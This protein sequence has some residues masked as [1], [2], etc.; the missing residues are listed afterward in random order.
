VKI[1]RKRFS[2]GK[3][4]VIGALV[5]SLLVTSSLS[6]IVYALDSNIINAYSDID[7]N[8]ETPDSVE[9]VAE[10]LISH[11][12]GRV[13]GKAYTNSKEALDKSYNNGYKFIELD[14]EWT[15]D[16]NLALIHDW[17][18]YVTSAFSVES[19]IY[20]SEEFKSFSMIDNLTQM[21]IDDLAEWLYDHDDIYI[22]TDV[23]KHNLE[24]L[25]LIKERYPDLTPQII[26]QIYKFDQFAPTKELGFESIILTLYMSNYTDSELIDFVR[27]HE[28]LAITMPISRARTE[29][30]K[31]LKEENIFVYAHTINNN[32][33]KHDLELNGVDGFYTDDLLPSGGGDPIDEAKELNLVTEKISSNYDKDIT[34][35]ELCELTVK[36]YQA[37]SG[38]EAV[39]PET[40]KFRDTN[41]PEILRAT[42]LGIV[43]GVND[44]KFLPNIKVTREE[45]VTMLY[46]TLNAVDSSLVTENNEVTF[47]DKEEISKWALDAVGFMNKNGILFGVGY[48]RV[49]PKGNT[50]REQAILLVRRTYDKFRID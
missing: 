48:S 44:S 41:N 21:T 23:K 9:L 20:S 27:E 43:N 3:N 38:K 24:A 1:N 12:G 37:L 10:P 49:E 14:F 47:A 8:A 22:V 33:L 26:P 16:G 11:A 36:L 19:K 34:R 5:A 50:T 6:T 30:P 18:G 42:V 2:L 40:N 15:S 31:K 39:L 32:Q 17:E 45:M 13:K 7:I 28:I 35:E 25:R 29:L 46:R 4:K